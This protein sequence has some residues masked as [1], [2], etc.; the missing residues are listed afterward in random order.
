MVIICLYK[1]NILNMNQ[2][3]HSNETRYQPI[4]NALVRELIHNGLSYDDI[5]QI[6]ECFHLFEEKGVDYFSFEAC[7]NAIYALG[8]PTAE[9]TTRTALAEMDKDDTSLV[10][11]DEFAFICIPILTHRQKRREMSEFFQ[12]VADPTSK[13]LTPDIMAH[14]AYECKRQYHPRDLSTILREFGG[15]NEL[16]LTM[17]EFVLATRRYTGNVLDDTMSDDEA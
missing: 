12:I 14:I 9:V 8:C 6:R 15:E 7:V 10:T 3:E 11:F 2:S 13:L 16:G 17:H 4:S 1:Y 5:D